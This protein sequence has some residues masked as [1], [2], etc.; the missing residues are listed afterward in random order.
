MS[1]SRSGA[2]E[3]PPLSATPRAS[4]II[5]TRDRPDT[6]PDAVASALAN[7]YPAFDVTVVDQS[8]GDACEMALAPMRGDSRLRYIRSATTGASSGRNAGIRATT[9]EIL[10]IT[11]DDTRV[12]VDWIAR[13]VATYQRHQDVAAVAGALVPA[14]DPSPGMIP[15]YLPTASRLVRTA[16]P[17]TVVYGGNLSLRRSALERTG[18]FDE[19][20]GPG[21]RFCLQEDTDIVWRLLRAGYALQVDKESEVPHYGYR[22]PGLVPDFG[23][24]AYTGN[25]A[26]LV[27][28]ARTGEWA[29]WLDMWHELWLRLSSVLSAVAH[30]RGPYHLRSMRIEYAAFARAFVAAWRV[31]VDHEHRVYLPQSWLPP[32]KMSPGAAKTT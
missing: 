15:S 22:P 27:K 3:L 16:H 12:P 2:P 7:D 31:P 23:R 20:L 5:A 21:T 10:L 6:L 17:V 13:H 19:L 29:A 8:A 14:F 11:D 28:Q 25:A 9:G 32:H 4:V 18:L 26:M 1:T 24:R 30:R